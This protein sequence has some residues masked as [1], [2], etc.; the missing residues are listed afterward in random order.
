LSRLAFVCGLWPFLARGASLQLCASCCSCGCLGASRLLCLSPPPGFCNEARGRLRGQH[1]SNL[2][3]G[4]LPSSVALR[5]SV[6]CGA[7]LLGCS[8]CSAGCLGVFRLLCLSP[9]PGFCSKACGRLGGQ[10]SSNLSSSVAFRLAFPRCSSRPFRLCLRCFPVFPC[11]FLVPGLWCAFPACLV[12]R[13]GPFLCWLV[14]WALFARLGLSVP[15]A[16]ASVTP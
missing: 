16:A 6:P 5:P 11:S 1:S 14:L 9:L 8:P 10:H 3:S 4:G 2:F 15:A 12:S 7:P 13:V